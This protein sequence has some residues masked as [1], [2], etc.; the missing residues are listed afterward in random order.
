MFIGEGLCAGAGAGTLYEGAYTCSNRSVKERVGLSAGVL[1]GG[2][3]AEKYGILV[4]A[5][6]IQCR[7]LGMALNP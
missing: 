7:S 5:E 4:S 3:L 1:C 6:Q 2:L